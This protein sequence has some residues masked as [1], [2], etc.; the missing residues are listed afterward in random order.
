MS[1]T[2]DP[3]WKVRPPVEQGFFFLALLV[4]YNKCL[5]HIGDYL[6]CVIIAHFAHTVYGL[7]I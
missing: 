4:S 6:I 5:N 7:C 2:T 3:T 1:L